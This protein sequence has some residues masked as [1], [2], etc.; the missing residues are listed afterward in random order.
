MAAQQQQIDFIFNNARQNVRL[1]LLQAQ[2]EGRDFSEMSLNLDSVIISGQETIK[3]GK[4]EVP[5]TRDRFGRFAKSVGGAVKEKTGGLLETNA[6]KYAQMKKD[7]KKIMTGESSKT[8]QQKK[9]LLEA[10]PQE[11]QKYEG[12]EKTRNNP[13][14]LNKANKLYAE[15][16]NQML[17]GKIDQEQY[18]KEVIGILEMSVP[19]TAADKVKKAIRGVPGQV[20]KEMDALLKSPGKA[21]TSADAAYKSASKEVKSAI[22]ATVSSGLDMVQKSKKDICAK[23]GATGRDAQETF[24]LVVKAAQ[25]G[26]EIKEKVEAARQK[27]A[28]ARDSVAD[29][30]IKKAG[31]VGALTVAITAQVAVGVGSGVATAMGIVGGANAVATAAGVTLAPQAMIPL[32]VGAA[33]AGMAVNKVV[34]T[35]IWESFAGETVGKSVS[36]IERWANKLAGQVGASAFDEKNTSKVAASG[37]IS[38]S[39]DSYLDYLMYS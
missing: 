10:F 12:S 16:F 36:E 18:E 37:Y 30:L 2:A 19:P 20:K 27:A 35:K 13:E 26:V 28:E 31:A 38:S 23:I 24:G 21:I 1:L 17:S 4:V 34:Q 3:R 33:V 7:Y 22:D 6:E 5:V 14:I 39:A 32:W 29:E 11:Y 8:E 15:L 9:E 25:E